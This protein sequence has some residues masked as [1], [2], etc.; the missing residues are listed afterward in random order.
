MRETETIFLYFLNFR[1][2]RDRSRQN[3]PCLFPSFELARSLTKLTSESFDVEFRSG[4]PDFVIRP[5]TSIG[6]GERT[7][8][9]SS[10]KSDIDRIDAQYPESHSPKPKIEELKDMA[11]DTLSFRLSDF[12]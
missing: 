11:E 5:G 12:N 3:F 7:Y 8:R 1:E 2:I 6:M 10:S 9:S 4:K